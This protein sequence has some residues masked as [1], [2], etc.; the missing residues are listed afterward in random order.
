[1]KAQFTH[2]YDGYHRNIKITK[3]TIGENNFTYYSIIKTI[4][5]FLTKE[6]NILD[7]GCGSGTLDF[8]LSSRC[9]YIKGIDIS[10]KA[11]N[12]CKYSAQNLKITNT[13][14]QVAIFPETLIEKEN[15]D[16]V[17]CIEII[18]HVAE[19]R[20]AIKNINKY[21]KKGGIAI[22]SV[23]SISAPLYKLGL[24]KKFD[25]RVGH[26]RRYS[27][28]RLKKL[29][30]E[31]SFKILKEKNYSGIIRDLIFTSECT[32][33]I[34]RTANKFQLIG[35]IITFLDNMS[36]KLFGYSQ[37]IIVAQKK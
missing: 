33:L 13:E 23:P 30:K 19:E 24:T 25:Q 14:F 31:A 12:T 27:S 6:K 20:K 18:E 5:P 35:D 28:I 3:K 26:I 37:I 32:D 29:L 8:Y 16:I 11:I 36:L 15:F 34:I 1:M 9:N 4:K 21:L 2:F 7:I 22:I 17:L 10:T